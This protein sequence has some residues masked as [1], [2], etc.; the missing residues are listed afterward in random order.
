M[1]EHRNK[2]VVGGQAEAI[3]GNQAAELKAVNHIEA[4]VGNQAVE[5]KAVNHI[6][7]VVSNRL[8]K[9]FVLKLSQDTHQE[10]VQTRVITATIFCGQHNKCRS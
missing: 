10:T 8:A 7:A 3:V 4:V 2:L 9:Y 1:V 5:L 6:E